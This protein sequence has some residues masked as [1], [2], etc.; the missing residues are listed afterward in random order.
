MSERSI[1]DIFVRTQIPVLVKKV[2]PNAVIPEYEKSGDAGFDFR[3]AET[4]LNIYPG[5][6]TIIHTGLTMAIPHGFE[7]QIR[8]RSGLS[9]KTGLRI[10]NSPGT[11]DSG[12]RGEIGIIAHNVGNDPINIETGMRIAQGVLK[13]TPKACFEEVNTL[14]DSDRGEGGFGH[15]GTD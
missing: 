2:R 6:T 4:I 14:P 1:A 15:T 3:A 12:Y 10:A 5:A 8:P 11:I 13:E 7:I 9:L